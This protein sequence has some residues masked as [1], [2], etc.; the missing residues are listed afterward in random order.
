MDTLLN[1]LTESAF[2]GKLISSGLLVIGMSLL[3]RLGAASIRRVSWS[4]HEAQRRWLV[5]ARNLAVIT[6]VFLL[7]VVWADQLRTLALSVVAFAAAII[8]STKELLMCFTGGMLRSS[9]GMFHL[10]DRIEVKKLRGDV[11]DLTMLTTTILEIGPEQLSHQHTGR[12]IVLPNSIFLSEAVI[13]ESFT[14][15]FVLHTSLVPLSRKDDWARAERHLLQAA[16][17]V[18][19]EF[20]EAARK[21]LS[22]LGRQQGIDVPSVEPRVT[23]LFPKP[24]EINLLVRF[25]VPARRKGRSEQ[26]MLRRYLSLESE[27]ALE[28]PQTDQL[29]ESAPTDQH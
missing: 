11:I 22:R 7:I 2:L 23:L 20:I 3:Y 8:L 19:D 27:A 16:N 4:T 18:C 28:Q 13:N 21:H 5:M 25:P 17:E 15:D 29:E 24:E 6:C 26:A 9:A 10:G 14:E 1:T 12:A